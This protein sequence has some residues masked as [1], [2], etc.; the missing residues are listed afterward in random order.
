MQYEISFHTWTRHT[1]V[2]AP[3]AT[4]FD[5]RSR[6]AW[7]RD[8]WTF[9]TT[10]GE[11]AVFALRQPT[12]F[13]PAAPAQMHVRL[14]CGGEP[15]G[16]VV[17]IT[18]TFRAVAFQVEHAGRRYRLAAQRWEGNGDDRF[19]LFVDDTPAGTFANSGAETHFPHAW[20][21]HHTWRVRLD[22]DVDPGLLLALCY[23]ALL[24]CEKGLDLWVPA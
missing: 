22:Q 17:G 3:G 9:Y 4:L 19:T 15:E 1:R 16:L 2:T 11:A 14:R 20:R 7:F 13:A 8:R 24:V 5:G 18:R 6:R 12:L 23:T 21:F 10:H